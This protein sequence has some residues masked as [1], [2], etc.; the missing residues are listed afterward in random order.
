[1]ISRTGGIR[2]WSGDVHDRE[3]S[4]HLTDWYTLTHII[5]GVGFYYVLGII[6]SDYSMPLRSLLALVLEVIW[7]IAENT[8]MI[9]NR[10]RRTAL[11]NGYSGDSIVNSVSDTVAMTL[12][13]Y[14]SKSLPSAAT[15]ALALSTELFCA[16][17]IRDNLMLNMV[18]LIYP[19]ESI[20]NWQTNV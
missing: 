11:A 4:Q 7:E 15:I 17:K 5:H 1:M 16:Y 2:I 3:N 9:I 14:L 18:Q 8:P 6:L 20:S 13:F 12:G 19:L 10:Y